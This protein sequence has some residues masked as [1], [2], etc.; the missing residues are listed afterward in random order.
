MALEVEQNYYIYISQVYTSTG[1]GITYESELGGQI[2]IRDN[3]IPYTEENAPSAMDIVNHEKTISNMVDNYN[4]QVLISK[5]FVFEMD[6]YPEQVRVDF[7][8]K[9]YNS[10]NAQYLG[11]NQNGEYF[12]V[13]ILGDVNG[14]FHIN[15]LDVVALMQYILNPQD[16][17]D[18]PIEKADMNGDGVANVLDAVALVNEI[19]GQ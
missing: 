1:E 19:L 3:F 10:N 5:K 6:E 9:M 17:P 18:F 15:V 13:D 16:Y 2:T 8:I 14:D 7:I 4:G 11:F 12:D